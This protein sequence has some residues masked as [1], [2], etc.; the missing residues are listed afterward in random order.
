VHFA[1]KKQMGNHK[2]EKFETKS[3]KYLN[4][5][6]SEIGITVELKGGSN[7]HE[8]D[9]YLYNQSDEFLFSMDSKFCP[10]QCGQIVIIDNGTQFEL[11]KDSKTSNP[12]T[13]SIVNLI[14]KTYTH[15]V[16]NSNKVIPI[17]GI[18]TELRRW[19][20]SHYKEK[21]CL[22]IIS[23]TKLDTFYNIIPITE[24]GEVFTISAVFRR[25]RS[26]TRDVPKKNLLE[27][28]GLLTKHLTSLG[29]SNF[30]MKTLGNMLIVGQL[31]KSIDNKELYFDNYYLSDIGNNEYRVKMRAQTNNPNVVFS[32]NYI[33]QT[34]HSGL[35][36]LKSFLTNI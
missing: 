26:G 3:Q 28:K 19:V 27:V 35:N 24:I 17:I 36:Q 34:T 7:S 14:N 5:N 10:A 18:D 30:Q 16:E 25:K 29:V 33:G 6:L 15:F 4:D 32:M 22:F 21:K 20:E 9:L 23:T 31:S 12:Y 13:E 11:S 1:L 2:W 8:T